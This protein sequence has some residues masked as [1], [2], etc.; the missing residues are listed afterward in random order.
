[1]LLLELFIGTKHESS[2]CVGEA[3]DSNSWRVCGRCVMR[4]EEREKKIGLIG[5]LKANYCCTAIHRPHKS[6][7]CGRCIGCYVT[8]SEV[9]VL[10][11]Q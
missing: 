11:I 2:F 7:V 9:L 10:N 8:R 1:M 3:R 5:G 4:E 6:Y